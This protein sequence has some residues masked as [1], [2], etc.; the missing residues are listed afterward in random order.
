MPGAADGGELPKNGAKTRQR[1]ARA[2]RSDA[3]GGHAPPRRAE[4]LGTRAGPRAHAAAAPGARRGAG[5]AAGAMRADRLSE[6]LGLNSLRG[7]TWYIQPASMLTADGLVEGL[8][9]LHGTLNGK[10]SKL[11]K[12]YMQRAG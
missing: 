1:A 5:G 4:R 7:H 3:R 11:D 12:A 6:L 8:D 9:W 2:R 10:K